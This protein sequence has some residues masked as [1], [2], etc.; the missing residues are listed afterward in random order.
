MTRCPIEADD[1]SRKSFE[2]GL[3]AWR[4]REIRAGRIPPLTEQ[5]FRWAAEGEV[6]PHQMDCAR[7]G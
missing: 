2:L 6:P 5:D 1:D 3:R 4:E 7:N